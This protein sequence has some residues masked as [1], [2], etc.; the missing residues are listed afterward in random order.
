MKKQLLSNTILFMC[1]V[2]VMAS[3]GKKTTTPDMGTMTVTMTNLPAAPVKNT[4]IV[5]T[6]EVM[7]NGMLT[8]VTNTTAEIIKGT[9]TKTMAC[10][11]KSMGLYTGTYTFTD[12]GTYAI[13]F[14]YSHSGM[15]GDMDFSV[16]IP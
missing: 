10:A 6:F 13:H 1:A 7:D 4:P 3:C 15:A 11:E 5:F 8:A 9:D 12:S 14:H 16:V 2:M